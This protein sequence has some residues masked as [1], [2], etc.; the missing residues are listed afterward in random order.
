[1]TTT[2][3]KSV[4]TEPPKHSPGP[5]KHSPGRVRQK[6]AMFLRFRSGK[7][8]DS[9]AVEPK[10]K[11]EHCDTMRSLCLDPSTACETTMRSEANG[12]LKVV[13]QEDSLNHLY[14]S[15]KSPTYFVQW[16]TIDVYSH[17]ILLGDNPSVSSGPPLTISWMAHEHHPISIDDYEKSKPERRRKVEMLSPR[18]RRED[19]LISAGYNRSDL[20][21]AG[22]EAAAIRQM[23]CRSLKDGQFKAMILKWKPLRKGP[24]SL[25]IAVSTRIDNPDASSEDSMPI[26]VSTSCK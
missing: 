10:S 1:M 24:R 25:P 12:C 8:S 4:W 13:T 15:E 21:A 23:R 26:L 2:I 7:P 5:F 18:Q 3:L 22:N 19:L 16:S 20:K 11:S 14:G 9:Y 17:E 6:M